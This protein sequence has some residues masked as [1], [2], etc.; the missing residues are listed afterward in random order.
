MKTVFKVYDY[1]N[2]VRLAELTVEKESEFFYWVERHP[3]F[4]HQARV[5]KENAQSNA[6][7]AVNDFIRRTEEEIA[8]LKE[9][10]AKAEDKIRQARELIK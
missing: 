1:L 5:F 6:E 2:K 4:S 9:M 8:E 10:V 7:D 3:A